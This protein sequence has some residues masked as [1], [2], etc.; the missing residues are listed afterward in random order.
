MGSPRFQGVLRFRDEI[1]K[2]DGTVAFVNES[3][4]GPLVYFGSD[5]SRRRRRGIADIET[6]RD[7]G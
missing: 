3:G 7:A 2:S 1:E 6:G 4:M 5:R